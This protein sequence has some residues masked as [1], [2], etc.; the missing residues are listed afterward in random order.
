[1]GKLALELPSNWSAERQIAR[2]AKVG[3]AVNGG[4]NLNQRKNNFVNL[5]FICQTL[6]VLG[7]NFESVLVVASLFS[8][9]DLFN[10]SLFSA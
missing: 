6:F 2:C 4:F 1:M 7:S 5:S 10:S 3:L 8:L 9:V